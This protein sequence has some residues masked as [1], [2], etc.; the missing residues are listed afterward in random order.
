MH[1]AHERIVY[2]GMKTAFAAEDIHLQTLLVPISIAVSQREADC[3]EEYSDLFRQLGVELSRTGAESLTVRQIPI[4]LKDAN[5]AELVRDVLADI[6]TH[7]SSDAISAHM[8]ELLSTMACHG[9]VRA[10]RR[11]SLLEMNVLLR[12]MEKT[13]RQYSSS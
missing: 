12:D 2:E 11:L 13:E 1:A 8:N 3:A 10:N 7:G 6:L 4:L 9:A 5:V